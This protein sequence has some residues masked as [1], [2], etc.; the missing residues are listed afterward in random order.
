M[1]AIATLI[2]DVLKSEKL[3]NSCFYTIHPDTRSLAKKAKK[4]MEALEACQRSLNRICQLSK[5]NA[6][7]EVIICEIIIFGERSLSNLAALRAGKGAQ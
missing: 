5:L 4:E 6:P 1:N 7:P 3:R 2:G